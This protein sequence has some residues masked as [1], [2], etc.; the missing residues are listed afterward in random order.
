M[1]LLN[2]KPNFQTGPSNFQEKGYKV[3]DL[4]YMRQKSYKIPFFH[5]EHSTLLQT[6]FHKRQWTKI[7][8]ASSFRNSQP[9]NFP[10]IHMDVH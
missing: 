6:I 1:R 3:V 7:M 9:Y 2:Y 8:K 4:K 10:H 5:Y